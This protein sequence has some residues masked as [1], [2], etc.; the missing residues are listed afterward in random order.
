MKIFLKWIYNFFASFFR[1]PKEPT[2]KQALKKT[3][4][5]EV[6]EEHLEAY[7]KAIRNQNKRFATTKSFNGKRIKE[8]AHEKQPEAQQ[9]LRLVERKKFLDIER[10]K[11]RILRN[12]YG[13]VMGFKKWKINRLHEFRQA[14]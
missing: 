14:I 9:F 8:I 12:K 2:T 4:V 11:N 13:K 5:I 6:A 7:K 10:I 1:A 3:E